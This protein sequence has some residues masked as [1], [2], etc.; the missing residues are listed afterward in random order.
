MAAAGARVVLCDRDQA[1]LSATA[2]NIAQRWG[3]EGVAS[4]CVDVTLENDVASAVLL[5]EK[6]FGRVDILLNNAG[7]GPQIVRP[8]YF[9]EPLHCWEIP[10]EKWRQIIEV[11]FIAPFAFA[12]ALL[13]GMVARGW[14]RVINISTTWETMLRS[15]FASYGPSKAALEAMT[16][17]MARELMGTGVTVNTLHPGGPVDTAQVP[18]DIGVP[19]ERLLRPEVMVPALVWVC[20]NNACDFSGQRLTA[21]LW[22]AG[23]TQSDNLK[24]AAEPAAWPQL[25]RPIMM[26]D[27]GRL[28]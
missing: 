18:S 25:V 19:R 21:A 10:L 24:A 7:T 27:R 15:G 5:A 14:G 22:A 17:A 3:S 23:A 4:I 9:S 11:N 2:G 26:S 20:S 13:P 6:T 28:T 1:G 8:N 12:R 16:V